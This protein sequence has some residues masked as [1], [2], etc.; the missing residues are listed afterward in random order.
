MLDFVRNKQ[1]SIII[2]LAFAIIILSFVIGYAML[3]APG[4]PGGESPAAEAAVINGKSI[5]YEDF[6]S[7]YSNLYQIYQNIYQDQFTPALEKELKLAEKAINGLVD[8]ALMQDEAERLQ[9]VVCEHIAG[10][11]RREVEQ[12]GPNPRPVDRSL[13]TDGSAWCLP[14]G[15]RC[16]AMPVIRRD[17][18]TLHDTACSRRPTVPHPESGVEKPA[19]LSRHHSAAPAPNP[20]GV[21]RTTR[22]GSVA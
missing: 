11:V 8:Q 4:G 2:K 16:P 18:V 17:H 3:S 7:A 9:L 10:G 14:A 19:W 6:Q 12:Q 22:P 13:E 21:C 5:A 15:S 1:K 20:V